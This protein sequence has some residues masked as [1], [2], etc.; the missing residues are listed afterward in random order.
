MGCFVEVL[1][2]HSA[3][4]RLLERQPSPAANLPWREMLTEILGQVGGSCIELLEQD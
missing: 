1:E 2:D 3:E 4:V